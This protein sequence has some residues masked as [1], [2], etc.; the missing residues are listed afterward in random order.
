[1]C[2]FSNESLETKFC[3]KMLI[4]F[5]LNK[6]IENLKFLIHNQLQM[7]FIRECS[8]IDYKEKFL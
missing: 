7:T 1:M 2:I 5:Y 8:V 4:S 3:S 6:Y